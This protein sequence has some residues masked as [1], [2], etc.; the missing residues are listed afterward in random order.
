M[1]K[2]NRTAVEKAISESNEASL[3]I[4]GEML[5]RWSTLLCAVDTG[6]LKNSITYATS[7]GIGPFKGLVID[8]PS[9]KAPKDTVQIGTN[10]EYGIYVDKGT[11]KAKAQP[12]ISNLPKLYAQRIR[13]II[14][15]EWLAKFGRESKWMN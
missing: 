15:K 14:T 8:K 7:N 12:F 3:L 5:Q 10:V 13:E 11:Y 2:S 4:L 1:Y 6:R 9:G